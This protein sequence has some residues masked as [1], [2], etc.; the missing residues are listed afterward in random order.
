M[1]NE[2]GFFFVGGGESV[3]GE[4]LR[5]LGRGGGRCGWEKEGFVFFWEFLGG[6]RSVCQSCK[7]KVWAGILFNHIQGAGRKFSENLNSQSNR[8][9]NN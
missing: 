9:R 2:R 8:N 4:D 3:G 5:I 6:K 1:E 7:R